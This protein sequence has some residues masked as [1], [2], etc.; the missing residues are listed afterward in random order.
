[1]HDLVA[2]R[3]WCADMM[4]THA[5]TFYLATRVLPR[6]KRLAVEALYA[7][8]RF[9][10]D[11]ADEPGMCEYERRAQFAAIRRDLAQAAAGGEG[12]FPWSA[13]LRDALAAFTLPAHDL[14]ELAAGC[15][16]DISGVD[17]R[18]MDELERY[19]AAVAGTV[20][21]LTITI[22]GARDRD[23][24]RRATLLG[25]AMQL[26]NVVRDVEE[27]WRAGRNY[28]P[29]ASFPG[30]T[31]EEVMEQIADCAR[32]YYSEAS[33]LA[34]R[35]PNDGSRLSVLL[36]HTMYAG[37]LDKLRAR[38]YD[39]RAGRAIVARSDKVRMTVRSLFDAYV[40]FAIM[41]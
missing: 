36:A 29:R 6:A 27:D 12:G 34:A 21:R 33:V 22:L 14:Y 38:R 4:R 25:V 18:T 26:T 24:L 13:A 32:R 31:P 30:L 9:A 5:S 15:E 28:L 10:D 16:S 40:G 20:G 1:M 8:C 11:T 39:W 2:S 23:S 37:I 7:F 41:R 35:L 19:S 3:R 17:V